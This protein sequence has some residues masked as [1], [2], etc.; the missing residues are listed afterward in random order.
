M[1]ITVAGIV[2]GPYQALE[3]LQNRTVFVKINA[4]KN[5]ELT[6]LILKKGGW[7]DKFKLLKF[8]DTAKSFPALYETALSQQEAEALLKALIEETKT[9]HFTCCEDLYNA[10]FEHLAVS[11]ADKALLAERF[12][13]GQIQAYAID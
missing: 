7:S 2:D 11:P 12:K 6:D 3:V 1:S 5:R 13:E 9:A 4:E 10:Y 8:Y